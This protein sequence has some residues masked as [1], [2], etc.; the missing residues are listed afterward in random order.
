M[1]IIRNGTAEVDGDGSKKERFF[2]VLL[3]VAS[4]SVLHT[5]VLLWVACQTGDPTP[6]SQDDDDGYGDCQGLAWVEDEN[7]FLCGSL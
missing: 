5:P 1:W 2:L 4:R 3:V 6:A 7:A